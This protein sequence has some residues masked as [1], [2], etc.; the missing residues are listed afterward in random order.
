MRSREKFSANRR[1]RNP[2]YSRVGFQTKKTKTQPSGLVQLRSRNPFYSR[3]GFQTENIQQNLVKIDRTV[4]IPFIAGSGFRPILG[5]GRNFLPIEEV[6]I[7]FIA[8]SG[9]RQYY[10]DKS[11][12]SLDFVAIP[13]IAGS[14]FRLRIILSGLQKKPGNFSGVENVYRESRNP[15]YSRVG[16]QTRRALRRWVGTVGHVAIPFIAGSGFRQN[17]S[18]PDTRAVPVPSQS[19][20]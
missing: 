18:H 20:L 17:F 14:G 19:L 10:L 11:E 6:A 5:A 7:P 12:V 8:G 16:F 3:V 15:F 4:A 13:F 9:F 1:G 2:F